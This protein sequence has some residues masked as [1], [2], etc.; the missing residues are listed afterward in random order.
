M[1][2][3]AGLISQ[4][5]QSCTDELPDRWQAKW[6]L[7]QDK[8]VQYDND[9][10]PRTLQEWLEEVYFDTQRCCEL[11]KQDIDKIGELV[12]LLLRWEPARRS[13]AKDIASDPWF[14]DSGIPIS[15]WGAQVPHRQEKPR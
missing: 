12:R 7:M 8:Q 3:P 13:S 2:T 4:M 5:I 10:P 14:S 6:Q 1:L 9:D 15:N 11:T